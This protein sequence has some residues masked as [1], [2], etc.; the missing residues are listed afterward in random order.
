MNCNGKVVTIL[1][2][3]SRLVVLESKAG[4]IEPLGMMHGWIN[5]DMSS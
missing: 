2:T 4:L 1:G 5:G 3:I